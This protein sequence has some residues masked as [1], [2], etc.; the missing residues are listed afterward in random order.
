MK[1]IN[2]LLLTFTI[3]SATFSQSGTTGSTG[4]T[5]TN[6]MKM[7]FGLDVGANFAKFD[8]DDEEFSNRALIPSVKN[9][10]SFH[11][12]GFVNIPISQVVS[13][14]P[15]IIYSRQG[16]E[17]TQPIGTGATATTAKYDEDLG[18]IYV[19]PAAIHLMS[20]QGLM[21]ESG[22]MLGFL[23]SAE[24]D[25]QAVTSNSV[26]KSQRNPLDFLWSSG[27]GYLSKVGLGFHARYNYGF[28]NI[29]RTKNNQNPNGEAHN[30]IIQLGLMYHFGGH[31]H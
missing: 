2:L 6:R 17:V 10:T 11:V 27:I 29:Y 19:A 20:N 24:Q 1:K 28:S 4:T 15:Q 14:K 16:S 18:Y 7:Q 12:G 3:A 8:L 25:G 21:F 22:P 23:V 26:I 31:G 30:R 13:L 9:K 5:G